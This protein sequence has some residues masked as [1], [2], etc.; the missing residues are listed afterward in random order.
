MRTAKRSRFVAPDSG[1]RGV[2][3]VPLRI[4]VLYGSYRSDKK[5]I[6]LAQHIW[7]ELWSRGEVAELVDAKAVGLPIMDRMYKEYRPGEAPTQMEALAAK[8]RQADAFVFVVGEYNSGVQ[9]G[10][11]NLTG[12]FLEEWLWRSAAIAS[13]STGR[14]A[15]VR[16]ARAWRSTL[17]EMGMV[18]VS[19]TLAVGP[20]DNMLD[21]DRRAR[22]LS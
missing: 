16:A 18:V 10:L 14:T 21:A 6:R 13:Y 11:E 4:L 1:D 22:P 3:A 17:S 19:S 9:P 8:I 20:I 15:G 2:K 12:Y 7:E 5:G